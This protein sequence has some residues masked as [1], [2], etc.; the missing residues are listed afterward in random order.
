MRKIYKTLLAIAALLLQVSVA[1]AAQVTF[2][3]TTHV[4]GRTINGG[5]AI[6]SFA[7]L[8]SGLPAKFKRAYCT[9]SFYKDAA[10]TQPVTEA[11]FKNGLVIYVD[12][13]FDPPFEISSEGD[14]WYYF[15]T[16]YESSHG[17]EWLKGE[18]NISGQVD[19][20]Y[21]KGTST[22][23]N[24]EIQKG[25][26]EWAFF[27]DPYA[28]QIKNRY[29]GQYIYPDTSG[30]RVKRRN[31]SYN[32]Q[33]YENSTTF[34]T[35][36]GET[37]STFSLT[38]DRD[39]GSG[40]SFIKQNWT[41]SSEYN[42][43]PSANFSGATVTN[44]VYAWF[45]TLG[46]HIG[47]KNMYK[48]VVYTVSNNNKTLRA[49]T[50]YIVY[51]AKFNTED[52]FPASLKV[53]GATYSFYKDVDFSTEYPE[54]AKGAGMVVIYVKEELDSQPFVTDHW[55]T[56]VLPY[57]VA[58]LKSEFGTTSDGT[59]PAVRVLE[60]TEVKSN[61]SGTRYNL[62][63]EQKHSME[64]NKPY[65]FK[66]DEIL[67]G[68]NL[69]LSKGEAGKESDALA[70][71]IGQKDAANPNS[72]N[73]YM[74]GTY[75]GKTLT[76]QED[77]LYFYFGWVQASNEYNFYRVTKKEVNIPSYRCYFRIEG[78]PTGAKL[79]LMDSFGEV[80]TGIDGVEA[81]DLVRTTGRI[82]NLN[83]Q[84]VGNDLEALP[85]GVYIVNGKKV[86]K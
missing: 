59:T 32:W 78:A 82:Y 65:L 18:V 29:N 3:L 64:A 48:Y 68:K 70:K 63:F 72:A 62:V 22:P 36:D 53:E 11:D 84:Q 35:P 67:E 14:E 79:M 21:E 28:L 61:A 27:G 66:A 23:G 13:V 83:G 52:K 80:I 42:N 73:V 51:S 43:S 6:N 55:I 37:H 19:T 4:D 58:D 50:D 56:L 24:N 49:Q 75:D 74:T 5:A 15:L 25:Y 34:T 54:V 41:G 1:N 46:M 81:D 20:N 40:N 86:M 33:M 69:S 44:S 31:N 71:E 76:V 26:F 47:G 85:R 12:Y 77:P 7:D 39:Y 9:Y 8:Q 16:T 60:Y 38:G 10:F 17:F 57:D 30:K 45:L 2:Y